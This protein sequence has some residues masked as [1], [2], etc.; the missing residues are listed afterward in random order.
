MHWL[1]GE[2]CGRLFLGRGAYWQSHLGAVS[3]GISYIGRN[4]REGLT[5]ITYDNLERIRE[6]ISMYTSDGKW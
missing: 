1:I 6:S 2:F 4:C 5:G 3:Y